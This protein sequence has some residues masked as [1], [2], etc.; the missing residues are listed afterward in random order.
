M[1]GKK[2]PPRPVPVTTLEEA[3]WHAVLDTA[4]DAII[5]IDVDGLIRLFNPAAER[6]FGYGASEV[7]GRNVAVLM[8]PQYAGEHTSH[9]RAYERTGLAGAIGQIRDV[10]A[11][12]K[13][14]ET[15]PIELSVSEARFGETISYV[16]IIR[17]VSERYATQEAL[18]RER[19]LAEQLVE[20]AQAIVLVLDPDARIVRFNSYMEQLSGY[21]LAEVQ[22]RDWFATFIPEPERAR[23]LPVFEDAITGVPVRGY[24]NSIVIRD[25]STREIEWA[26]N[27]LTDAQGNVV[28][29]LAIGHDVTEQQRSARRQV[30]QYTVSRVLAASGSLAAATPTVLRSICEAVGWELGEL[31]RVD[32][33]GSALR[34][35]GLWHVAGLD[36]AEFETCSRET[37]IERH[38]SLPGRVWARGQPEWITDLT[39]EIDFVRASVAARLGLRAAFA[40]PIR[41]SEAVVGVMAF[42][43]RDLR[44]PDHALVPMLEALGRQIGAFVERTAAAEALRQ[45]EERFAQFMRHLPGVAFM[46][47]TDGRYVF[48]NPTFEQL[49]HR[50]LSDLAG[51]TDAEVWP[52]EI[53]AQFSAND[54][55]VLETGEALLTTETVPHDDGLHEW[56]VSKFPVLDAGGVPRMVAGIAVDVTE[57]RHA[58]NQLRAMQKLAQQR[59]RLADIGAI[60]AEIVHDLGNPLA[61]LSMQV[62][63]ILRRVRR[64]ETQPVSAVLKPMERIMTEVRRLSS[65]IGEFMEFSREQR[66]HLVEV[67]LRPFFEE[68]VETWQPLAAA[69][70]IRVSLA[71]AAD[72][73]GLRGDPDK[74][75]RVFDNLI[76]NALEAIEEPP[77]AV[78]LDVQL[79]T[80]EKVRVSVE[81]SGSGIAEGIEVF[82]LFETTKPG[83]SGLGLAIAKQIVLAHGGSIEFTRAHPH[84]TTFCIELPR[85]GPTL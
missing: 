45:V 54:R 4:P 58:E 6:I 27:A 64:D 74:L 72:A 16:A 11:R 85:H 46:K 71:V 9:L 41:S 62:Q 23:V 73:V 76:K 48:V 36:T 3:R 1:T 80:S 53:A 66:L 5:S 79:P 55:R 20:T 40:F 32:P 52:A 38:R 50:R 12:R 57:R 61:A 10:Q 19:D 69:R 77:G 37:R 18:R 43:T 24:V 35:Y 49:Y 13:N 70:G 33:D 83:G 8:P 68:I 29:I 75:R 34:W 81:D 84:G 67:P 51:R 31:W 65:W 26:G 56:L 21:R 39:T 14:G 60:T 17:D 30:A 59:E 44:P 78:R 28:G 82:R 42:F 47:D 25:G 15:F 63:L 22:G 2:E 7:M